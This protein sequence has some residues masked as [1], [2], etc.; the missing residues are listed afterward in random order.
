MKKLNISTWKIAWLFLTGRKTAIADYALSVLRQ[1]LNNLSNPTKEKLQA[2]LNL[3]MKVLSVLKVV[4][5][6]M[7]L[8]WQTAYVATVA[9][10]ETLVSALQDLD[11]SGAEL[12]AITYCYYDA[13]AALM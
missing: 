12:K 8:R 11:F 1:A 7:P 9:A 3:A 10:V 5:V 6:F 2:I 4:Q 13:Y